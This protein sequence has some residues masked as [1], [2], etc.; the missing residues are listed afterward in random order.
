MTKYSGG[1]HYEWQ[2][3]PH[4]TLYGNTCYGYG[5]VLAQNPP[6]YGA[7]MP[8]LLNTEYQID[9]DRLK[10]AGE[11][12]G[13]SGPPHNLIHH[14]WDD[15]K[16]K[17]R[18]I[19]ANGIYFVNMDCYDATDSETEF[20]ESDYDGGKKNR[21]SKRRKSLSKRRK[22]LKKKQRKTNRKGRK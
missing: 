6:N 13:S 22:S 14:F 10:Y 16:R 20:T 17:N 3:P 9:L 12:T 21:K 1:T 8:T 15:W 4:T 2:S 18:S 7:P 5:R 11:Y 19:R